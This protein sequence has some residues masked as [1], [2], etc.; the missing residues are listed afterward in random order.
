M[1]SKKLLELLGK[2][3]SVT[4]VITLVPTLI[5]CRRVTLHSPGSRTKKGVDHGSGYECFLLSHQLQKINHTK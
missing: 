5:T 4:A 1:A 2:Q 3:A